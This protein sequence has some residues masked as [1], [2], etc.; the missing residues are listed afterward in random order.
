[1]KFFVALG[2]FGL[3]PFYFYSKIILARNNYRKVDKCRLI[4]KI[5]VKSSD[6]KVKG[7]FR[8][9][10]STNL[11]PER[12]NW[13]LAFLVPTQLNKLIL[14]TYPMEDNIPLY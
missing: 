4:L 3:Q 10:L 7:G 11:S 5:L 1:M 12:M 13:Q 6:D 2:S 9:L 8:F 14:P